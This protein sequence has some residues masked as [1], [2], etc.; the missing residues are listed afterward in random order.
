MTPCEVVAFVAL[1]RP[2]FDRA[3]AEAAPPVAPVL[4][5]IPVRNR[6][7]PARV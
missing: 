7:R 6:K 4:Q 1:L 2:V 5:L 3:L